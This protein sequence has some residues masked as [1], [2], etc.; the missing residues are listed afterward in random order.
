M[1]L[2]SGKVCGNVGAQWKEVRDKCVQHKGNETIEHEQTGKE[3]VPVDKNVGQDI[4]TTNMFV[5][6]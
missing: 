4:Q 6:L 5:V 1:V 2:T 3:I